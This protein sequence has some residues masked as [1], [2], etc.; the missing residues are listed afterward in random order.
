VQVRDGQLSSDALIGK[1][2]GR[3]SAFNVSSSSN[4]LFVRLVTDSADGQ[5]GFT[6]SVSRAPRQF[7][8]VA[9]SR[10]AGPSLPLTASPALPS[11]CPC[12]HKAARL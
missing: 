8:A 3:Q 7:H 11:F 2:C 12:H 1:Y 10:D 4:S 9:N 5:Q 6:A